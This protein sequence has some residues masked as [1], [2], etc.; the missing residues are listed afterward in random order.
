M[1]LNPPKAALFALLICLPSIFLSAQS[2]P[3]YVF[4]NWDN[5][6]GL[7]QNTVTDIE[8]DGDGY[9]W[10][11]T[12]EG[13]I[14][15]DGASFMIKNETN[16]PGLHSSVFYDIAVSKKGIW[17]SSRNT[18]MFVA[19][20]QTKTY[21]FRPQS[22]GAW[23]RCIETGEDENVWMGTNT[24]ELYF[25][26]ND[27][28]RKY[29]SWSQ[30]KSGTIEVIRKAG[31]H[32]MIG[33]AKGLYQLNPV[34]GKISVIRSFLQKHITTIAVAAPGD[35]W[36]GT[37]EDGLF[38]MA[39]TIR[40]YS[41]KAGLKETYINAIAIGVNGNTWIGS[42]SSGF[43]VLHNGKFESPEQ[44]QIAHSGIKSILVCSEKEVWAGSTS[45]GL[46]QMKP[47]QI[48]MFMPGH[49]I[50]ESVIL[51]IYQHVSGEVWIGTAGKGIN[52]VKDGKTT[53]LGIENGLSHNLVLSIGGD[54]TYIYIG[55]A[56]GLDRYNRQ[57][58]KID[59]HFD[60]SQ[61]LKANT[62]QSVFADTRGRVWINTK[63]GGIQ[64]LQDGKISQPG[65]PE[66]LEHISF[67]SVYED[68]GNNLWFGSRGAGMVRISPDGK[69]THFNQAN[70]FG[71]D[72][73]FDFYEDAG[74][75]LW[76]ATEKGLIAKKKQQFT[77]IDKNAGLRFNEIYRV[78]EDKEGSIWL[79]GN[80]GLQRV[81][82]ADLKRL[83]E[84]SGAGDL[85]VQLFNTVDGMA[86]AETN[87][88]IF[89]AGWKMQDGTLWFPTVKGI[90]MVDA[91]K[92]ELDDQPI[93]INLQVLRYSNK[94]H[95]VQ[96]DPKIPQGTNEIE[97]SYT[98]IDFSKAQDINYYYRLVG[99][100]NQW[101][102]AGNRKTAYFSSLPHG[103]YRF[104]VK[105]EQYGN[106]SP[107]SSMTFSVEPYYYQATWFRM[108]M[109]VL[110]LG[111]VARIIYVQKAR[112]RRKVEEQKKITKAEITGQEKERQLIGTE[113]HDN[114]NQQL[115]TVKLY[116]DM[117]RS[118]E[119]MRLPMVEKTEVVVQKVIDE[120]RSL[121][122]SI[123]PPTLKDIGLEE[124][125]R[126][127]LDSYSGVGKFKTHFNC[128]VPLNELEEDLRFTL[129]RITQEQLNNISKHA[130]AENAWVSFVL[131]NG[132]LV[133]TIRDDGKGFNPAEATMG[134]GLSNIRN[135][136]Q[137]YN[138]KLEME[139]APGRGTEIRIG[140]EV[141]K[142][143]MKMMEKEEEVY[144]VQGKLKVVKLNYH[145]KG[146][147]G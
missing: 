45:S 59:Q 142:A 34:T 114:I 89:P 63:N 27:S 4:R 32:L 81:P 50:A 145:R 61:G 90:A 74:G 48:S 138:G 47:A 62:V 56:N 129:F 108:L 58:S 1:L 106:W 139:T 123:I 115:A 24:G 57:T 10:V 88:G 134:L 117:A 3:Q 43:Q 98:S 124:A 76:I 29:N 91:A 39:E 11:A 18:V 52:L 105:A 80:Y 7:P 116:L 8:K 44:K 95:G 12:E 143:R 99:L 118:D 9:L 15:F 38:H 17:A 136:L 119:N 128:T 96:D 121:C 42:R 133:L 53:Q 65:L 87:G 25:I 5:Q 110:V 126:D 147:Q 49:A 51:P 82:V 70:G 85:S 14:R 84:K 137:L 71:A 100:D 86:N 103:S 75:I 92:I 97:I 131:E 35:Y 135:R 146:E 33:T 69:L 28:I 101:L 122:K 102:K 107:V 31:E 6:N 77:I 36:I 13:L 54:E 2:L 120:I 21:D 127:L 109:G 73:A 132:T 26:S 60:K 93:D 67:L 55:T 141:D 22:N 20:N 41:I 72:I 23:I 140:I 144:S 104:E 83:V 68:R 94:E 37:T 40:Q 79:S 113:L 130:D 78:M 64:F 111:L 46:I 16:T 30:V 19:G 66:A 125:L 112:V